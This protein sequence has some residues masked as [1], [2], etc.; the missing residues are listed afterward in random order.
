MKKVAIE[1]AILNSLVNENTLSAAICRM[2]KHDKILMKNT[3]K[4]AHFQFAYILD[5]IRK[6]RWLDQCKGPTHKSKRQWQSERLHLNLFIG[7]FPN[8]HLLM[9]NNVILFHYCIKVALLQSSWI[10]T[11]SLH[12]K[13]WFLFTFLIY[14]TYYF[15]KFI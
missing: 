6:I 14:L 3:R 9:I 13:Y 11:L 12:L 5:I 7:N 1:P 8:L 10:F 4:S 15:M 2:V